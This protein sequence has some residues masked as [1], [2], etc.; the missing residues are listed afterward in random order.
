MP[1]LWFLNDKLRRDFG[2]MSPAMKKYAIAEVSSTYAPM[3][4]AK[5][6]SDRRSIVQE[7]L[8]RSEKNY[9]DKGE[10]VPGIELDETSPLFG[11]G[12]LAL[13]GGRKILKNMMEN[14]IPITKVFNKPLNN[15]LE[16]IIEH[17][18][19]L[20]DIDQLKIIKD[21]KVKD[22]ISQLRNKIITPEEYQKRYID[23]NIEN[24]I[25]L[26]HDINKEL[27]E[28]QVQRDILFTPQKNILTSKEQLGK[29][30]SDGGTNNKGVFE[31]NNNPN[32]VAKK[33]AF[34][35]DNSAR[36][37]NYQNKISSDRIMKTVQVKNLDN[38][39]YYIQN[40]A[41]GIP[42]RYLTEK[43]INDI[44]FEHYKN[45]WADIEELKKL[46]MSVDLSGG[47][48]N[49]FYSPD[50]GFE[51]IDIGLS[52]EM[53]TKEQIKKAWKYIQ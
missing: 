44:P 26:R 48:A 11:L 31:L 30:I 43:Q 47:R 46:K 6:E 10:Q 51:L 13:S 1:D 42:A 21:Q 9:M 32:F 5:K 23:L 8:S 52:G 45:F 3:I 29:N 38:D 19:K 50:K 4:P 41:S 28:L 39:V 40:K 37:I 15:L 18:T 25:W 12:A 17:E 24:D 53:P 7:Y 2:N 27:R 16:Q 49:I 14:N 34:G 36:L 22:F 33:S 20:K 35:Y